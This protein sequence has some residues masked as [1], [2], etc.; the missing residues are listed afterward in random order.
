MSDNVDHLESKNGHALKD[1]SGP[2]MHAYHCGKWGYFG[3]EVMLI[4]SGPELGSA[5][6]TGRP[7]R[8]DQSRWSILAARTWKG[9]PPRRKLGK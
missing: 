6:S 5:P 2:F 3:Y 1:D 7:T 8:P 9:R 4:K